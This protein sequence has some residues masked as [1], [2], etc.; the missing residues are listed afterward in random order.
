M[1]GVDLQNPAPPNLPCCPPTDFSGWEVGSCSM[2]GEGG[3]CAR[4][5]G[6][7]AT[8]LEAQDAPGIG[9]YRA[10]RLQCVPYWYDWTA[11]GTFVVV[12][13]EVM[14][15]GLYHAQFV[16]VGCSDTLDEECFSEPAVLSTARW[17][18]VSAVYQSPSPPL[19]QPDGLDV[20]NLV[21]KFKNLPG[22]P[23]KALAQLQPNVPEPN[24]DINALDIAQG[25]DSFKGFR[26]PYAGPCACPSTVTCNSVSCATSNQCT[27]L[28][29]GSMCVRTCNGGENDGLPCINNKHCN[30]CLGGAHDG[31]PCTPGAAGQCPGGACPADGVCGGGFCR[32]AC[33]RCSP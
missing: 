7:P 28:G 6:R 12:G 18:D 32:D 33:G 29:A 24:A 17:G 30:Y 15:S 5:V 22:A 31:R 11:E 13:A 2:P 3:G 4:W 9:A 16:D 1:V 14:P 10:A 8:F 19:T 25:V 21:N 26:Y 23:P 20:A 27:G